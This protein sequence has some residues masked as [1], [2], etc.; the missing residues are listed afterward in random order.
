MRRAPCT[1]PCCGEGERWLANQ[2]AMLL[3]CR[4][5]LGAAPRPT[6]HH[7]IEAPHRP[8]K[9]VETARPR[10]RRWTQRASR[11]HHQPQATPLLA[12]SRIVVEA[13][14]LLRLHLHNPLN[15]VLVVHLR[16]SFQR[17]PPQQ[18][19][20][21]LLA[22]SGQ[23]P[24][25]ERGARKR[26]GRRETG[27]REGETGEPLGCWAAR[28]LAVAA[29]REDAR[30]DAHS[31]ELR[32]VEVV[33]AARELLVVDVRRHA[34]LARV[35]GDDARAGVLRRVRELDLAVQA[36][37]AQER[38]VEDVGAVRRGDDLREGGQG[39]CGGARERRDGTEDCTAQESGDAF[40]LG[41]AAARASL[42]PVQRR[43]A[44]RG[45]RT[46][47]SRP[48]GGRHAP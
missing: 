9:R 22:N 6:T 16:D 17:S 4:L 15:E 47:A 45:V 38:G 42:Y 1:L 25:R 37:G 34:H 46:Q 26:K 5:R 14:L 41:H 35:D 43:R 19:G 12:R 39:P 18:S 7:N 40:S 33:R 20:R 32:G 30:L 24:P 29:E 13:R 31:L 27:T 48:R 11:R 23:R 28:L 3:R 8:W 36:A 2:A 44:R 21:G 10:Y